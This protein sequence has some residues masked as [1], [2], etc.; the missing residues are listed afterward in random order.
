M[1]LR[2]FSSLMCFVLMNGTRRN[3]TG[4]VNGR[5]TINNEKTMIK[6]HVVGKNQHF[7]VCVV[8]SE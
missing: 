4:L 6:N 1:Q 3:V 5:M 2:K 7:I 8:D